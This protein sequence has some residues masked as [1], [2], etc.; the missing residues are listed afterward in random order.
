MSPTSHLTRP[1]VSIW[2]SPPFHHTFLCT[3]WCVSPDFSL[4]FCVLPNSRH[5]DFLWVLTDHK[6]NGQKLAVIQRKNNPNINQPGMLM[7]LYIHGHKKNKPCQIFFFFFN[8]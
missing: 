1:G 8:K 6:L 3:G 2:F 5:P 4:P 7:Y